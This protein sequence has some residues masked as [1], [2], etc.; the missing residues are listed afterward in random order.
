MLQHATN[1]IKSNLHVKKVIKVS[2]LNPNGTHSQPHVPTLFLFLLIRKLIIINTNIFKLK[3][4]VSL[5]LPFSQK[6]YGGSQIQNLAL[7]WAVASYIGHY[8]CNDQSNFLI[9]RCISAA[10]CNI[11]RHGVKHW[12]RMTTSNLYSWA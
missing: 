9:I 1:I 10:R 12:W 11:I 4:V 6:S 5:L 7:E 8:T 2:A 3:H